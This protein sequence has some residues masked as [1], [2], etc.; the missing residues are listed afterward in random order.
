MFKATRH[1]AK[2]F[3]PSLTSTLRQFG[4]SHFTVRGASEQALG[5]TH[6]DLHELQELDRSFMKVLDSNVDTQSDSYKENYEAM[7]RTN[8]EL[9][10]AIKESMHVDDKYK[11]LAKERDKKLPRERIYSILDHGSPFLELS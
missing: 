8:E 4:A 1:L 7:Q 6:A 5:F 3:R 11:K 2:P 10:K 9:D